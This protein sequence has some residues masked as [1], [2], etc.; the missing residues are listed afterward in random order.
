MRSIV[1]IVGVVLLSLACP[2]LASAD[3]VDIKDSYFKYG[4]IKYFRGNAENIKIGAYGQKKKPW[5]S[6]NYLAVQDTIMSEHLAAHSKVHKSRPVIIDWGRYSKT[7]VS[8]HFGF[9]YFRLGAKTAVKGSYETFKSAKL[10]LVKF[11]IDEGPMKTTINNSAGV[12]NY[13]KNEGKSGRVVVAVWVVVSAELA[14]LIEKST[15][16]T[17]SGKADGPLEITAKVS[18]SSNASGSQTIILPRGA[19][20][21]YMLAKVNDWNDDK[22][23]VEGLEDDSSGLE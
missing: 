19:A 6:M 2:R 13:L 17:A 9:Q 5:G 7:A 20:F 15:V 14:T 18:A 1:G 12:R 11:V 22:T 16:V 4:G 8:S 10:K 21:A 3:D 23:Q